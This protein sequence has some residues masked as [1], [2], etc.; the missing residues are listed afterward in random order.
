MNDKSFDYDP[1]HPGIAWFTIDDVANDD[2]DNRSVYQCRI[3]ELVKKGKL[4]KQP[5]GE[6]VYYRIKRIEL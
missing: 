1:L 4:I 2:D 5:A 3:N 6:R